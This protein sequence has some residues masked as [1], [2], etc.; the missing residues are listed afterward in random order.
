M[1]NL[2]SALAVLTALALSPILQV[3]AHGY[4][5][6]VTV[7]TTKYTGY[8]PDDAYECPQ[9]RRIVRK[10]PPNWLVGEHP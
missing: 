2:L 9:P 4:V 6:E 10:I 5:Q 3:S 1:V 7:G 8:L